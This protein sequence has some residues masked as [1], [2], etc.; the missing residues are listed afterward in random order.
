MNIF[1]GSRVRIYIHFF[2]YCWY[3]DIMHWLPLQLEIP[4]CSLF[5]ISLSTLGSFYIVELLNLKLFS[6]NTVFYCILLVVS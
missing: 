4:P 1:I 6:T 5:T 2:F 3:P